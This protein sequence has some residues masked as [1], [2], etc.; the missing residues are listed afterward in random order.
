MNNIAYFK[1]LPNDDQTVHITFR[2][3]NNEY[4]VDRIFN[5]SR[6]LDES[7]DV[8]IERIKTNVEKEFNKKLNKLKKSKKKV[9][10][11]EASAVTE[12][13]QVYLF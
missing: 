7:I 4:Q 2:L 8:S 13:P 5:F 3:K 12:V 10:N 1:Q 6:K 11:V 9:E